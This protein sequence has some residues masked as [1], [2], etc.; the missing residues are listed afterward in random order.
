M[1]GRRMKLTLPEI[2]YR[3]G[4]WFTRSMNTADQK[5][6]NSGIL[7]FLI[8]IGNRISRRDKHSYSGR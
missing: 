3:P 6:R 8:W 5:K 1:K 7:R 4:P 2:N